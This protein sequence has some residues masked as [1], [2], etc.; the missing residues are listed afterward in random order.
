MPKKLMLYE[1]N[2]LVGESKEADLERIKEEVAKMVQEENV[3][4]IDPQVIEK[5]RLA[6]QIKHNARGTY[7]IQRFEINEEELENSDKIHPAV[8]LTKKLNLHP[9]ILRFVIVKADTLPKLETREELEKSR[10]HPAE[11]ST[12]AQKRKPLTSPVEKT[13]ALMKEEKPAQK[14]EEK[15]IDEKLEEILN[16]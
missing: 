13:A 15:S 3:K 4:F 7:V 10:I 12:F 11:K 14:K 5:R 6:Y 1:L 2:Y 9:D 8:S 16:I